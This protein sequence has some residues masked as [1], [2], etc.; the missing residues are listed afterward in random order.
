MTTETIVN[1]SNDWIELAEE[2]KRFCGKTFLSTRYTKDC[3]DKHKGDPCFFVDNPRV[4]ELLNKFP[5]ASAD[6]TSFLSG[7]SSVHSGCKLK[8]TTIFDS[9]ISGAIE[10][11]DTSL[12]YSKIVV[13]QK[14]SEGKTFLV[15]KTSIEGEANCLA[16][17]IANGSSSSIVITDSNIQ[18][19]AKGKS[20]SRS[21]M[22]HVEDGV[23]HI[24]KS[25]VGAM[26]HGIYL[27]KTNLTMFK[28]N[29]F[30][31]AKID[32]Q[33]GRFSSVVDSEVSGFLT[34]HGFYIQKSRICGNIY[35]SGTS[36]GISITN[37][38]FRGQPKVVVSDNKLLLSNTK[39]EGDASIKLPLGRGNDVCFEKCI[40]KDKAIVIAVGRPGQTRLF[41][42]TTFSGDCYVTDSVCLESE[43]SGNAIINGAS[44]SYCKIGGDAIIGAEI[45]GKLLPFNIADGISL[46]GKELKNV[47]DF[48]ILKVESSKYYAFF[49]YKVF[50]LTPKVKFVECNFSKIYES[51]QKDVVSLPEFPI[52]NFE[53]DYSKIIINS[54]SSIVALLKDE[55]K[56]NFAIT[57]LLGNALYCAVLKMCVIVKKQSEGKGVGFDFEIIERI[58]TYV[59]KNSVL[60]ISK[61]EIS[62][63]SKTFKIVPEIVD[64][65]PTSIM[66]WFATRKLDGVVI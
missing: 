34:G 63:V 29:I 53:G 54:R 31:S 10:I 15:S 44:L 65:M 5:P 17:I 18:Q 13:P 28:T 19:S 27:S 50:L 39:I 11:S 66:N 49:E 58:N 1:S 62:G 14:R 33:N 26:E 59:L 32:L 3:L 22:I 2:T 38:T 8:N 61:K 16:R 57:N 45:D 41:D 48:Y 60:D 52:K 47:C 42:K 21:V 64:S 40:L 46:C 30:Q 43:I 35:V 9:T 20:L 55:Y 36:K 51:A 56:S 7:N 6:D 25:F 12:R 4:V 23:L 24:K 37:S